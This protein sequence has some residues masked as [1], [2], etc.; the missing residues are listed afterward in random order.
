MRANVFVMPQAQFD[1]WLQTSKQQVAEAG[2]PAP[3]PA[4]GGAGAAGTRPA[5][6]ADQPTGD[7]AA[8]E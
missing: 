7:A 8:S 4:A 2:Q 1:R 6:A 5:G 3:P